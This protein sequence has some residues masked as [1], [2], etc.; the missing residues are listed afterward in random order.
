M[1]SKI[2]VPEG[3]AKKQE[4]QWQETINKAS[5]TMASIKNEDRKITV[6]ALVEF[7]GLSRSTFAKPH[8]QELLAEQG[9]V[10]SDNAT[11][12]HSCKKNSLSEVASEKIGCL[13][14]SEP[15]IRSWKEN[16][17]C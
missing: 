12:A 3:L 14:S 5:R 9:P 17:N 2:K 13:Q 6:S 4:L 11:S 8:I 16:A 7:I 10:A 15:Q 1:G